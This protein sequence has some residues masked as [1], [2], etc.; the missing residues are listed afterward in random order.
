MVTK[1]LAD[2]VTESDFDSIP[3][4]VRREAVRTLLN[5]IGCAVGG[6]GH[7]SVDVALRALRPFMG[8]R[9][10]SLLGRAEK[11]DAL[12]AALL[13]GISSHVFDF[14]DT[15]LKTVI[16]PGGPVVSAIL[17]LAEHRPVSGRNFLH[18]LIIGVEVECRIGNAVFPAHYDI[19]WHI[20]GTAGVFGAAAGAG[21]LLGLDAQ[22]LCWA[23]GIAATQA[24]GLREMFGSMCKSFH[25]GRAAQNGLTSAL[26]AAEG[27][28]SSECAIEAPRGFANVLSTKQDYSE[29]TDGLGEGYEILL[30]TYKPF[31]CGIVIHPTIDGCLQLS[32]EHGLTGDE[33]E[34]VEL[35]VHP[36]V[37]E[38]TGKTNP[39]TGLEAKFSVYHAAAVALLHGRAGL[40][41]FS[42]EAVNDPRVTSLRD[43]VSATVDEGID[44]AA[45]VVV[46]RLKDGRRVEKVVN[47][48]VGSLERPLSDQALEAKVHGLADPILGK[49]RVKE[50]IKVCRDVIRLSDVADLAQAATPTAKIV[51]TIE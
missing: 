15:H 35:R 2:W 38:L 3:E 36:L 47:Q 32:E 1:R 6:S 10:A 48:A 46:V 43:S 39:R 37:L 8:Q 24:A 19:G 5:W 7:D 44:E 27:F 31:P 33:V 50:M 29:I 11:V 45:V 4:P 34:A 16:H 30:N 14:D 51:D 21:L 22:R 23:L 25:I 26:L 17:A 18:A 9:N 49:E 41:E 20:T 12:N 40:A 42:D 13:N 28:T